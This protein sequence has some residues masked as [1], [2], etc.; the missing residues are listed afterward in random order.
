MDP[1]LEL[2]LRLLGTPRVLSSVR[3]LAAEIGAK[4]LGLLAYLAVNYPKPIPREQL[5]GAFWSDK[6][7]EAARYRLRHTLWELRRSLGDRLI[8]SDQSA[9]WLDLENGVF[10]DVVV[11]QRGCRDLGVNT[12]GYE[13]AAGDAS[14]LQ[15]LVDLYHGELLQGLA[16]RDAP[17]FEE[18]L[19]VERERLELLH[20]ETLWCLAQAQRSAG[21]HA[22]AA[23]TLNRLI[24]ADPLRERSYRTLMGLHLSQGDRASALRVY[25]QCKKRLV[26]ELGISPSP[27]TVRLH[28]M[29]V[30]STSDSAAAELDRA[31]KLLEG[32]RFDEALAACIAADLL[33]P[34]QVTRSQIALLRAEIAL[35]RGDPGDVL[36]FIRVA[37]RVLGDVISGANR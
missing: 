32:G 9:S 17:L 1:V 22:D 13:P 10:V 36:G 15:S 34:D 28:K 33:F 26:G 27:D 5:A 25:Q 2:E 35:A 16:V 11:F 31:S 37:R 23:R 8:H 30:Q 18:W 21:A 4:G 12:S 29:I 14:R 24:E 19:L 6:S 3:G 7:D 20:Q